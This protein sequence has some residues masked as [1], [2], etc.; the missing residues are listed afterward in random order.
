ML[1]EKG[2]PSLEKI[3]SVVEDSALPSVKECGCGDWSRTDAGDCSM[4]EDGD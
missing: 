1:L 4:A 2:I 3:T